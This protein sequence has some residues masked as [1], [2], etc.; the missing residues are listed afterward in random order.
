VCVKETWKNTD[1]WHYIVR[2]GMMSSV[3]L[4]AHSSLCYFSTMNIQALLNTKTQETFS[5]LKGPPL[6]E[7][8]V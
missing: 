5:V 8:V 1:Q 2:A 3:I 7:Q 6:K 4:F